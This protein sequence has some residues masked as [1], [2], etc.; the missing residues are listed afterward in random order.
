MGIDLC[1]RGWATPET[2]EAPVDVRWV[3]AL[4][5][6][7]TKTK[8]SERVPAG[9]ICDTARRIAPDA[10]VLEKKGERAAANAARRIL[11][12]PLRSL[13]EYAFPEKT[14]FDERLKTAPHAGS[15]RS[16]RIYG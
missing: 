5:S 6:S 8:G 14:D 7:L 1:G 16:R 12:A 10:E 11:D 4:Q 13:S 2:R 3:Q 15:D 9:S